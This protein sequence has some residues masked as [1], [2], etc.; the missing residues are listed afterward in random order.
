LRRQRQRLSFLGRGV[1]PDPASQKVKT[2]NSL[3]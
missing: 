2:F 3:C 1:A